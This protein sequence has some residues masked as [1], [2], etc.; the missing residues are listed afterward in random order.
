MF[1][2]YVPAADS[3]ANKGL[4]KAGTSHTPTKVLASLQ[5]IFLMARWADVHSAGQGSFSTTQN[6]GYLSLNMKQWLVTLMQDC[7]F[8]LLQEGEPILAYHAIKYAENYFAARNDSVD[9]YINREIPTD[10]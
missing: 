5:K 2:S 1:G 6:H 4:E 9:Y 7:F 3:I 8:F 10:N